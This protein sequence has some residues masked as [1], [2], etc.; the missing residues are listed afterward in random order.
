VRRASEPLA[1]IHTNICG[2]MA[3]SSIGGAKYFLTFINDFFRL[4]LGIFKIR[5][6]D[7]VFG[8]FQE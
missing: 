5:S 1:L 8:K 4:S 3:T 2:S 7:E 6:K